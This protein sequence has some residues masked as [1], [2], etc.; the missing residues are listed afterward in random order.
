MK[1]S[2]R[3]ALSATIIIAS[4]Y[5]G[6]KAGPASIFLTPVIIPI[7]SYLLLRADMKLPYKILLIPSAII[8]NDILLK[9]F[10]GGTYDLEGAAWINLL[11]M[12]GLVLATILTFI[13]LKFRQKYALIKSLLFPFLLFVI[14]GAYLSYFA[15]YGLI[16]S[17][18]A[19][20]SVKSSKEEGVYISSLKFSD[21]RII[22]EADTINLLEGWVESERRMNHQNLVKKEELSGQMNYIIKAHNNQIPYQ[23]TVYYK[24]NSNDVNGS[25]P[26]DSTIIFSLPKSDDSVYLTIFKLR[27]NVN[28]DTIIQVIKITKDNK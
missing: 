3:V 10:A 26:I 20:E 28:N 25:S 11:S 12:L 21:Q 4:N 27:G 7:V 2:L 1:N 23:P 5:L 22:Y 14:T 16:Q 17:V 18:S 9:N 6:Y 8:I 15:L 19:S 24:I 13:D